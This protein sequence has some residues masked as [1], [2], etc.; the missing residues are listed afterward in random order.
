MAKGIIILS[1][2]RSGSEWLGS[3]TNRTGKLGQSHEWFNP[4]IYDEPKRNK[5]NADRFIDGVLDKASTA[6]RFF[7]I[8]LFPEQLFQFFRTYRIDPIRAIRARNDVRFLVL[9]RRDRLRQAVSLVR[10]T[11]TGQW[12]SAYPRTGDTAYDF[13]AICQ[14]WLRIGRSVTFWRDYRDLEGIEAHAFVYEDLASDPMPWIDAYLDHSGE[15]PD[16]S[17][18]TE[19]RVQQDAETRGWMER[20]SIEARERGVLETVC[21]PAPDEGTSRLMRKFRRKIEKF[22]PG[23]AKGRTILET[24]AHGR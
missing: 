10:A 23:T 9:E 11:Q 1:E 4:S 3:L 5:W 15:K 8:K 24:E 12:T 7:S 19:L 21:P 2:A 18:Q 16:I 13:G 14:A 22:G 6:N 20:F 17:L